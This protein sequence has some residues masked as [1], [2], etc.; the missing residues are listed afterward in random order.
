M[1]T[2]KKRANEKI[3][4]VAYRVRMENKQGVVLIGS[5]INKMTEDEI[6]EMLAKISMENKELHKKYYAKNTPVMKTKSRTFSDLFKKLLE[7]QEVK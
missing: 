2:K 6:R 1:N 7:Y 3:Q 5:D 4:G